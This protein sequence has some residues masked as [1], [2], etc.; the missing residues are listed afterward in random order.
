M[1]KRVL[2]ALAVAVLFSACAGEEATTPPPVAPSPPVA[3]APPPPAPTTTAEAPPPAPKPTLAELQK[4]SITANVAAWNAHDAKKLADLYADDAVLASPGMNGME[5]TKGRADIEKM[6]AS[7][8]AGFP[9]MKLGYSRVFQRGDVLV[10]EWVASGTNTGEFMGGKATG[11]KMGFN[12]VSVMWFTDDGKIKREHAY[13]DQ[14]TISGQLGM[15]DP[16][17]P[18]RPVAEVPAGEPKWV[19]AE[20]N[21]KAVEAVKNLYTSFEKKDQ[22]LFLESIADDGVHVD[23]TMPA[24]TKG[25]D[26][27]KKEFAAMSKSFPDMKMSATNT[28]GFGDFVVTEYVGTGTFKANMGPIK[29]TNKSGTMHGLDI[30]ETKDGKIARATSYGSG[31]EF[32]S[33]YGLLPKPKTPPAG[34]KKAAA[35][36]AGGDKKAAPAPAKSEAKPAAPKK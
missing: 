5:E 22:K 12:A 8:A 34:D 10:A 33:Q 30:N 36:A 1:A 13:Y 15:G 27:A 24:D 3:E 29:A 17:M 19:T 25:K 31:L 20:E 16:K 2:S 6:Y 26:A 35:P 9:D 32:A 28:W 23:Y 7:L 21:P 11:K 4:T 14:M 18:T